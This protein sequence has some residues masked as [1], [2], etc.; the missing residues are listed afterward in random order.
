MAR[1]WLEE[2][3]AIKSGKDFTAFTVAELFEMAN[4]VAALHSDFDIRNDIYFEMIRKHPNATSSDKYE[5]DIIYFDKVRRDGN[6]GEAQRGLYN[7][8]P[9]AYWQA[10]IQALLKDGQH[11]AA[12]ALQRL[13]VAHPDVRNFTPINRL[14]VFEGLLEIK[15]TLKQ[16][17]EELQLF[18]Q[19]YERFLKM[20]PASE[21]KR[22]RAVALVYKYYGDA[23]RITENYKNALLHYAEYLGYSPSIRNK[24]DARWRIIYCNTMIGAKQNPSI[25]RDFKKYFNHPQGLLKTDTATCQEEFQTVLNFL[26]LK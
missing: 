10:F 9:R 12:L 21:Q 18:F 17:D 16:V 1:D 24:Q 26:G 5:V 19:I 3:K 11:E 20:V 25:V 2:Y 7:M 14:H 8:H 15:T 22:D 13:M 4:S 23:D 6:P